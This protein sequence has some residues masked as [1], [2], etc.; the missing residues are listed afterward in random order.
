MNTQWKLYVGE[1]LGEKEFTNLID[2]HR[3]DIL[4]HTLDASWPYPE[5][6]TLMAEFLVRVET[7]IGDRRG[8]TIG[9][10]LRPSSI[11]DGESAV[12]AFLRMMGSWIIGWQSNIDHRKGHIDPDTYCVEYLRSHRHHIEIQK[13]PGVLMD[14]G[15]YILDV[16]GR[17]RDYKPTFVWPITNMFENILWWTANEKYLKLLKPCPLRI[18]GFVSRELFDLYSVDGST[19]YNALRRRDF[20]NAIPGNLPDAERFATINS[21]TFLQNIKDYF[22]VVL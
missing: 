6:A 19:I 17:G 9:E 4:I 8:T 2:E 13:L 12:D 3:G 5:Y 16:R 22:T 14:L 21:K 20:L 7:T 10:V 18:L 11:F 15:R 1:K